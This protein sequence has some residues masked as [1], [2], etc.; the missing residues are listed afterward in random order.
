MV[1]LASQLEKCEAK[2]NAQS[3]QIQQ[4]TEYKSNLESQYKQSASELNEVKF[5]FQNSTSLIQHSCKANSLLKEEKDS[6]EKILQDNAVKLKSLK[7]EYDQLKE[8]YSQAE[9]QNSELKLDGELVSKK[10]SELIKLNE[11][12][13]SEKEKI[14]NVNIFYFLKCGLNTHRRVKFHDTQRLRP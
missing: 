7:S 1:N 12:L 10:I 13:T 9:S 2:L 3:Q 8:K 4:L 14:I 11:I 6:L 5:R